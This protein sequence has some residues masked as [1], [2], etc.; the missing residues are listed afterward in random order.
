MNW[1][2]WILENELPIRLGF[3]IGIFVIMAIWEIFLPR[4]V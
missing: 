4:R 2:D 3:F 1:N